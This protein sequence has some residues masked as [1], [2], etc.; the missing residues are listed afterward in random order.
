MSGGTDAPAGNLVAFQSGTDAGVQIDSQIVVSDSSRQREIKKA[1]RDLIA[2]KTMGRWM[3]G[4][5]L[6]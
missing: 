1:R 6:P 3:K 4:G 5:W 2:G